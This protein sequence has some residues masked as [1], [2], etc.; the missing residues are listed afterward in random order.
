[1]ARYRE[2]NEKE[3]IFDSQ[4]KLFLAENPT[5]F[6]ELLTY[7]ASVEIQ[8]MYN[9][10]NNC[11]LLLD[12]YI[13]HLISSFE[14]VSEFSKMEKNAASEADKILQDY[15]QLSVFSIA[16][17]LEEFS[18]ITD[19]ISELCFESW[20]LGGPSEDEFYSSMKDLYFQF[21]NYL[22]HRT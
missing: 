7:Q 9:Q 5:E 14:F 16:E 2:L 8:M 10:K 18:N 1:M 13:H 6:R 4:G 21:K 17:N 22:D 20:E 15:E 11:L 3:K 19:Q 12:K